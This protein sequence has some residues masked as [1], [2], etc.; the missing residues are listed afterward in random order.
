M[1]FLGKETGT[2]MVS[3]Y[4]QLGVG[5][6]ECLISDARPIISGTCQSVSLSCGRGSV[7]TT[8]MGSH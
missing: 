1:L 8:V 7:S 6:L 4:I 3:V 2:V 5:S